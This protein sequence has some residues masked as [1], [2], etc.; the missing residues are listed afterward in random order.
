MSD[1]IQNGYTPT[2]PSVQIQVVGGI[3]DGNWLGRGANEAHL[4]VVSVAQAAT[5]ILDQDETNCKISLTNSDW[6]LACDWA[7]GPPPS[8]P[9]STITLLVDCLRR[10]E[11]PDSYHETPAVV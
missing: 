9:L 2:G 6:S 10:Q 3:Y 11:Y 4:T 8:L 5:F 1:L 7:F